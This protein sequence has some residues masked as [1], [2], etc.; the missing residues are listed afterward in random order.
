MRNR[1]RLE[2]ADSAFLVITDENTCSYCVASIVLCCSHKDDIARSV[3][4][5][6]DT[7]YL[8]IDENWLLIGTEL[9]VLLSEQVSRPRYMH[10]GLWINKLHF[11]FKMTVSRVY[12]HLNKVLKSYN[13]DRH[14]CFLARGK[15][16]EFCFSFEIKDFDFGN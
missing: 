16:C 7:F 6:R 10:I 13:I 8:P 14:C 11:L 5:R 4:I 1:N 15:I 3:A 2:S 12:F 9:T